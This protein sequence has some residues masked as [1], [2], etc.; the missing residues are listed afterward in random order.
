[1]ATDFLHG[2]EIVDVDSGPRP[3]QTIRSSIIGLVGTAPD[4]DDTLFPLNKPVLVNSRG[5][6]AMIGNTGTLPAALAGIFDQFGAFVVVV[7]V[8]A[9]AN[10]AAATANVVGGVDGTTGARTG[11]SALLDAQADL[12]VMPMILIAPG[13][14][15]DRPDDPDNAGQFLA[16]PVANALVT[17]A[18]KVRA[19]AIVAGP[20]TTDADAIAY[21]NDFGD[22]RIFVVDPFVKVFD[23]TTATYVS[24]D[25]AARIAGL[26][27]RIDSEVGFW[28]S[29]SNETIYNVAGL[30]RSIDFVLGD[31]NSRANLLNE[32][33]IATIIRDGGF[34]L[35][36][37]RTCSL[38]AAFA[39][40]SVSRT[41]DMIDLSIQAAHR[42][43]CDRVVNRAYFDEVTAS[44]NGYLRQ[45]Q[46]QGA[47]LGGKCWVD[48]DF[49][50]PADIAAGHVTFS[51]DFTPPTPAERVTFR[52]SITD[53][54]VATLFAAA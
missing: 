23:S 4:A 1:M 6:F 51:Y 45:L 52:S 48:P 50:T 34:M 5:G 24:E 40:L 47:I 9:G 43:A 14:T 37:N 2:V 3:I 15:S 20:N 16:N 42:W 7:R 44:V 8:D 22:R 41:A 21:R 19:H 10:A 33:Q 38:D 18:A 39:F 49:N 31:P 32:N 35:W 54:Y 25:P 36:G 29:P 17:L 11:I 28:K 13:F 12:G 53:S 27:A 46:A 30:D 26:I